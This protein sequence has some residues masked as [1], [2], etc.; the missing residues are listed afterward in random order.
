MIDGLGER[1]LGY[2]KKDYLNFKVYGYSNLSKNPSSR[3]APPKEE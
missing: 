3:K 1:E 2:I